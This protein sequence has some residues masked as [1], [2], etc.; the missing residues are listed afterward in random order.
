MN[1]KVITFPIGF[2]NICE[3]IDTT[4]ENALAPVSTPTQELKGMT[5]PELTQYMLSLPKITYMVDMK[6]DN[7]DYVIE[8]KTPPKTEETQDS[9]ATVLVRKISDN[10]FIET[11]EIKHEQHCNSVS[12][13]E[14]A[15][16]Y[17]FRMNGFPHATVKRFC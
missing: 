8:F 17:I 12:I 14:D 10:L 11:I 1:V 6:I 5:V 9:I 4:K 13:L 3:L 2:S 16:L 15:V 7:E